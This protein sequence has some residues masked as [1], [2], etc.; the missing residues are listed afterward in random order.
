MTDQLRCPVQVLKR[1]ETR[2]IGSVPIGGVLGHPQ[3][4]GLQSP[5]FRE[6]YAQELSAME[7][8]E[9]D[10][11]SRVIAMR[12]GLPTILWVALVV[13]GVSIIGL[14]YLIGMESHR[15]HL[16]T[17]GTLATGIVLVLFTVAVLDRPFGTDFRV[18]PQ[19]FELVLHEIDAKEGR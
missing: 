10:R 17:V 2:V 4:R 19:P 3:L 14:S 16:L 12:T 5:T 6:F 15:L 13:L 18:G 7:D 8:L 9:E 1:S 11:D